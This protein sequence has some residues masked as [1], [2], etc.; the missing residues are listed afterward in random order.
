M[1]T[2]AKLLFSVAVAGCCLALRAQVADTLPSV[3]RA[4]G[5]GSSVPSMSNP[6]DAPGSA[7]SQATA[8]AERLERD[9]KKAAATPRPARLPSPRVPGGD[10]MGPTESSAG[11]PDINTSLDT[12]RMSQQIRVATIHDRPILLDALE[13]RV[14]MGDD[15]LVQ[16]KQTAFRLAGEQRRAYRAA[17]KDLRNARRALD[18]RLDLARA[19]KP[20]AWE[21]VRGELSVAYQAY[22]VAM[23]RVSAFATAAR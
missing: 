17:L 6:G 18:E 3:P 4:D 10:E 1:K 8:E 22:W 11:E 14:A 12:T 20:A 9:L 23:T 19:A 15:E 16:V 5:T 21:A 2:Q 7:P 13:E